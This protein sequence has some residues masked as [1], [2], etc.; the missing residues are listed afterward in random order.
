MTRKTI[1][2]ILLVAIASC[3]DVPA[4]EPSAPEES[5]SVAP[6]ASE[7][8]ALPTV[9]AATDQPHVQSDRI[10]GLEKETAFTKDL[11]FDEPYSTGGIINVARIDLGEKHF[12][13]IDV[14]S[15]AFS[16]T[17]FGSGTS[18]VMQK[19]AGTSLDPIAVYQAL[20]P[21]KAIPSKLKEAYAHWTPSNPHD[22]FPMQ[23]ATGA[24]G[25]DIEVT[26]Q[27]FTTNWAA[28]SLGSSC[29]FNTF[30]SLSGPYGPFC[31]TSNADGSDFNWCVPSITDGWTVSALGIRTSKMYGTVC[32]NYGGNGELYTCLAGADSSVCSSTPAWHWSDWVSPG[33][34]AQRVVNFGCF[35]SGGWW[36]FGCQECD[37]MAA[38]MS[39]WPNGQGHF[40]GRWWRWE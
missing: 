12:I 28:N 31:P 3:G 14:V 25:S 7:S 18:P 11:A 29:P 20:A 5:A 27:A 21:G 19:L 1:L 22:V 37:Y 23:L 38:K 40:G 17:E 34:W 36:C 13:T 6:S 24:N 9:G 39:Y 4:N 16:Y 35:S 32:Q 15:N 26:T 2:T 8:H 10:S 30:Q 33:W